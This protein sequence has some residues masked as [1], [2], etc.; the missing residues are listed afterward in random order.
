MSTLEVH[1]FLFCV[2]LNRLFAYAGQLISFG[3]CAEKLIHRSRER[4]FRYILR[5]DLV[6]F[7]HDENSAGALTS[8]LSTETKVR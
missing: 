1:H 7:D 5:Q 2:D 3:L 4:S 6:Y 8:L